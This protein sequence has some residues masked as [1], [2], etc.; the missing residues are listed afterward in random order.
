MLHIYLIRLI[1]RLS[2]IG[3]SGENDKPFQ[4]N[5]FMFMPM[6]QHCS[7]CC[8]SL[9]Y[10]LIC[11]D[12]WWWLHIFSMRSL[13][14]KPSVFFQYKSIKEFTGSMTWQMKILNFLMI[15]W[16]DTFDLHEQ[17]IGNAAGLFVKQ[18]A[19][20]WVILQFVISDFLELVFD[21]CKCTMYRFSIKFPFSFYK[22]TWWYA[23]ASLLFFSHIW[24]GV[25]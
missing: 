8:T 14:C 2:L 15:K 13:L 9:E 10:I 21:V 12:T 17:Y 11:S 25:S 7:R 22:G 3:C 6:E 4:T 16:T 24:Y 19:A 20:H 1:R 18:I 5:Q 23:A